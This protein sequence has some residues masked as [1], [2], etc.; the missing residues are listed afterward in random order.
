MSN[1]GRFFVS[2][3]NVSR[4]EPI[5]AVEANRI[6]GRESNSPP[7]KIFGNIILNTVINLVHK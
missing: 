6:D 5:T 2:G 7:W 4:R 1:I 3:M